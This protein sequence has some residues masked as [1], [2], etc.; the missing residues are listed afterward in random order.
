MKHILCRRFAYMNPV[1]WSICR[2]CVEQRPDTDTSSIWD[3]TNLQLESPPQGTRRLVD[4]FRE[5]IPLL[6]PELPLYPSTYPL[7]MQFLHILSDGQRCYF[8]SYHL[9]LLASCYRLFALS[10]QFFKI[11]PSDIITTIKIPTMWNYLMK[12]HRLLRYLYGDWSSFKQFICIAY[13]DDIR[14]ALQGF[15]GVLK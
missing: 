5:H 10:N 8:T 11:N 15:S 9:A 4:T 12:F 6:L 1:S 2:R 14:N 13:L 7:R 3:S